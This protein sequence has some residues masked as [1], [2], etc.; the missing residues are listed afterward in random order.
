MK[1][2][3]KK[4][5]K[6]FSRAVLKKYNPRIIGITG[7]IGKTSTRE[8]IYIILKRQFKVRKSVKDYN[9]EIEILLTILGCQLDKRSIFKWLEA[10]LRG[11][12]LIFFRDKNYPQILIL[13]MSLDQKSDIRYLTDFTS[14]KIGVVTTI[15]ENRLS[16]GKSM[17]DAIKEMGALVINLRE[18]DGAV[19]NEDDKNVLSMKARTKANVLT[20]GFKEV[21]D[22]KVA[23][24]EVKSDIIKGLIGI[25][26]KLI[27]EG[28][29]IPMFLPKV[30]GQDLIYNIL[31]TIAVGIIYE[32]NLLEI[33]EVLRGYQSPPGRMNLIPGVKN[34]SIIDDTYEASFKSVRTALD[35]LS[36]MIISGRKW[37][38]LGGL[39]ELG[40]HTEKIHQEIGEYVV[41]RGVDVLVTVG[42]AARG[43][44]KGALKNNFTEERIY[45]FNDS[46]SAGRFIQDRIREGDLIL[47]KGSQELRMEKIVKELMAEPLRA[48]ELLVRQEKE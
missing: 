12:K 41:N 33:S 20:Y 16:P 42:G 2:F 21:A 19:L 39:V 4:I 22:V 44:A 47:I 26:F 40:I 17:E 3:L 45:N 30:L 24:L 25:N 48:K 36:Q 37:A 8:A 11:L 9:D 15:D 27:H 34:T 46:E 31:A 14:Q 35:I 29:V 10:F 18:E 1:D 6:I 32:V 5:L 43:I 38:V 7:S 13:E 28:K 23:E